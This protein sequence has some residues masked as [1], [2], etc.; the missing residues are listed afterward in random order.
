MKK[1]IAL[2]ILLMI[3]AGTASYAQHASIRLPEGISDASRRIFIRAN[4]QL[5][6]HCPALSSYWGDVASAQVEVESAI[7]YRGEVL[8][9]ITELWYRIKIKNDARTIPPEFRAGGHTLHFY[10]GGGGRPGIVVQ[11]EQSQL[12]CGLPTGSGDNQF[13]AVPD[14]KFIDQIRP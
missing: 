3:C 1:L 8:G 2:S 11:K 7:G 14:L 9:W 13:I 5:L 12:V 10:V 6:K 4:A